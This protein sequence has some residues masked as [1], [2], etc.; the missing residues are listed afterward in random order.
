M[1]PLL[2]ASVLV[3]ALGSAGCSAAGKTRKAPAPGSSAAGVTLSQDTKAIC[4]EADRTSTTFGNTLIADLKVQLDAKGKDA[5]ARA[6]AKRKLTKDV[7]DYSDALG[8]MSKRAS[9]PTLK[10]TLKQMSGQV[11]GFS[12]DLSKLDAARLSELSD[13]L[14]RAC[15]KG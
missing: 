15:G 11:T 13:T 10:T 9:D 6:E 5:D 14:D 8:D 1:K 2:A 4:G 3:L 12:G 7:S